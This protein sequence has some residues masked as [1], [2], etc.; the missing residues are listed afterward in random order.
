MPDS[1]IGFSVPLHRALTQPILLA[2]VPRSAAITIGTLAAAVGL[3]LQQFVVGLI[4]WAVGHG[5]AAQ[6]A[7]HE[8]AFLSVVSRHLR[9]KGYVSC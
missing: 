4:I 7:K 1:T 3:G 5:I 2:G 8:P 9:H 6:L